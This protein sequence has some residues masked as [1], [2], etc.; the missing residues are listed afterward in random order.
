MDIDKALRDILLQYG[1]VKNDELSPLI[2]YLNNL[3]KQRE[4]GII[5]GLLPD[6]LGISIL[7]CIK[8]NN[9]GLKIDYFFNENNDN[10][11][12]FGDLIDKIVVGSSEAIKETDVNYLL[13]GNYEHFY[14]C[15]DRVRAGGYNGIIK[16]LWEEEGSYISI[17]LLRNRMF[18]EPNDDVICKLIAHY[19]YIKD[20]INAFRYIN[21]YIDEKRTDYGKYRQLRES[22]DILLKCMQTTIHKRKQKDIVWDWVDAL[23]FNERDNVSF[24]KDKANSGI[25]F[26]NM[27][28]VMPR[29]SETLKV[30]LSGRKTISEG[31]YFVNCFD[32]KSGLISLIK[33]KKYIF[34]NCGHSRLKNG[35][36]HV[37]DCL[38]DTEP[39][40]IAYDE[41]MVESTIR[42]WNVLSFLCSVDK[43]LFILVHNLSE[44]HPY[45][46]SGCVDSFIYDRVGEVGVEK[47][48]LHSQIRA[49]ESY[50]SDQLNFYEQFYGENIYRVCMSDHGRKS[51]S[52]MDDEMCHTFFTIYGNNIQRKK[53]TGFYSLT[54][55]SRIMDLVLQENYD[56]DSICN[57]CAIVEQLDG[58]SQ[59]TV[60][61]VLQ[62]EI[63]AQGYYQARGIITKY[64]RMFCFAYG[65][66]YYG[67]KNNILEKIEDK[68]KIPR[69]VELM[70]KLGNN[71]IDPFKHHQLR[72]SRLLYDKSINRRTDFSLSKEFYLSYKDIRTNNISAPVIIYGAGKDGQRF[73]KTYIDKI[74]IIYFIDKSVEKD[75]PLMSEYNTPIVS[76]D[77]VNAIKNDN[78]I[79]IVPSRDYYLE[80]A[81][82][83]FHLGYTGGIDYYIWQW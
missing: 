24:L 64:D 41:V 73:E 43:K 4:N 52:I 32:E 30:I 36:V 62:K 6:A 21:K 39:I 27:Y 51:V 16:N 22:L 38:M 8:D 20:F 31:G 53:L 77:S 63:P 80:M 83:L 69:M 55:F 40:R 57:D 9:I 54:Q 26:Q 59:D 37:D 19:L 2:D 13:I 23:S 65:D 44:T 15:V 71:W 76:V 67:Q 5:I 48:E 68:N 7:R 49:A 72:Y 1:I 82:K 18:N 45:F 78:N 17:S 81:K 25:D 34:V 35:K 70:G 3:S 61:A 74:N 12:E 11:E 56:L 14:E 50:F 28:T 66:S 79:I 33:E 47:K 46:L 75:A 58:Y 29:T 60:R 10:L 42:H